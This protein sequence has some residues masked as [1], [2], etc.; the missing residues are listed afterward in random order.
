MKIKILCLL[1]MLCCLNGCSSNTYGNTSGLDLNVVDAERNQLIR[2][3][4]SYSGLE[5]KFNLD[6]LN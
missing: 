4:N 5:K 6:F 3:W 2:Q 1:S